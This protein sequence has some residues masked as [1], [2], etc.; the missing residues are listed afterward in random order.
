MPLVIVAKVLQRF[1]VFAE[2]S[3]SFGYGKADDKSLAVIFS[4]KLIDACEHGLRGSRVERFFCGGGNLQGCWVVTQFGSF[5]RF[6]EV[7]R[8]V[9]VVKRN[10]R[11][12]DMRRNEI[13]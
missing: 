8:V 10:G 3:A 5:L 11:E 1:V 4:L 13:G 9:F 6:C 7:G 12:V 2:Q